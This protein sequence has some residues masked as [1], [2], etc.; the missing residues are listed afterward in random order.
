MSFDFEAAVTAPFRMQPG[1]RRVAPGLPHLTPLEPGSRKQREKLAVLSTFAAQAL[2][3]RGGFDPLPA[4]HALCAHAANEH[5]QAWAWDGTTA[6]ARRLGVRVAGTD[7][8]QAAAGSFGNG[9]EVFRCVQAQEP[10]WRLPALLCLAFAEDFA[11]VDAAD[12]TVPWLAV[13]LPSFWAPETKVGHHFAEV[14]AP[15]ADGELLRRG[16]QA[17]VAL[18]SGGERWERFV[19]NVTDHSRLHAHPARAPRE[20][21]V[22]GDRGELPSAWWRTERQTFLPV[23]E[24][25]CSLFTIAVDLQPLAQAIDSPERAARLHAAVSTMSP[26]VLDYRG[27]TPVREALLRWLAARGGAA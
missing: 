23:P 17:L 26:A 25:R 21:W 3:V 9:D 12:A 19:W 20:R 7:V 14:H 27:L 18:V 11:I 6:H 5:P 15:V 1:L 8:E 24:A 16:A 22:L 10:R 13:V 2:C 4:L